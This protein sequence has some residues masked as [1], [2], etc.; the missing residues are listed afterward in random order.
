MPKTPLQQFFENQGIKQT[1]I[2]RRLNSR[3]SYVSDLVRYRVKFG[4]ST[5][6]KWAAEFGL[7]EEWLL[8]RTGSMVTDEELLKYVPKESTEKGNII[9]NNV[10]SANNI[11]TIQQDANGNVEIKSSD[12]DVVSL[13]KSSLAMNQS[14]MQT[15]MDLI[16][17]QQ[18][19]TDKMFALYEELHETQNRHNQAS[20]E[21]LDENVAE[22]KKLRKEVFDKVD[23]LGKILSDNLERST[24]SI[25]RECKTFDLNSFNAALKNQA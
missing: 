12:N 22:I 1:E 9:L 7:S 18:Q 3:T 6:K 16:N 10:S 13:L 24:A 21:Y 17:T 8:Y 5:A 11:N 20:R 19:S 2:V 4:R 14:L 23:L 25:V 15:M